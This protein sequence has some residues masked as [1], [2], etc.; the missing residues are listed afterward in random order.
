MLLLRSRDHPATGSGCPVLLHDPGPLGRDVGEPARRREHVVGGVEA[1]QRLEVAHGREDD[2]E[3]AGPASFESLGGGHPEVGDGLAVV[4]EADLG[5]GGA[6]HEEPGV[7]AAGWADGCDPVGEVV[8]GVAGERQV[9]GAA[10]VGHGHLT[11]VDAA[12]VLAEPG[13]DRRVVEAD[14]VAGAVVREQQAALLEALADRGDPEPE[15]TIIETERGR[16]RVVVEADAVL[17]DAIVQVVVVD[18]ATWEHE[19]TADEHARRVAP[20]HEH[21]EPIVAVAHQHD[22]GGTAHLDLGRVDGGHRS[23]PDGGR[24]RRSGGWSVTSHASASWTRPPRTLRTV[25]N[26][27]T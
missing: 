23:R 4:V 20:Q 6:G 9:F 8:D 22:G 7:V 27:M 18:R 12:A 3:L 19:R 25:P 14:D 11:G 16:C 10:E 21:L 17:G 13:L 24:S 5:V 15:A 26:A 2:L 1:G